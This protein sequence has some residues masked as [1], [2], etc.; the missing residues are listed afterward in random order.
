MQLSKPKNQHSQMFNRTVASKSFLIILVWTIS[1]LLITAHEYFFLSN[2]AGIL[3]T[4]PMV[5][6]NFRNNLIAA[7]FSLGI[8]GLVYCLFEFLYFQKISK[9]FRFWEAIFLRILFYGVFVLCLMAFTSYL[10]NTALSGRSLVD[11]IGL[12]KTKIFITSKSLLH[13]ILPFMVL[14]L[15]SSFFLQL[16]E[17][18]SVQELNRMMSGRYF[19]PKQEEKVILFLDLNHSTMLAEKLG[20]EKFYELINDFFYDI[21]PVI[22]R[23]RGEVVEYVGDQIIVSWNPVQGSLHGNC[24]E[25][26]F[27]FEKVIQLRSSHY[28]KKYGVTPEFK[29]AI[30]SGQVIIGEIGK[31]KK[32]IKFNGDVLNTTSRVEGMCRQ[33]GEKLLLT[34]S[35]VRQFKHITFTTV[36]IA[37]TPLRGKEEMIGIYKVLRE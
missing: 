16:T 29:V 6:Y 28:Q 4:L 17:R 33:L 14:I 35:V 9:R 1:G 27:D 5:D 37:D 2:Y 36:K 3:D 23:H 20:N 31:I 10:Y 25:C 13:P 15:I 19:H 22:E 30:H 12:A 11:P 18:F 8:G 26:I 34:E 7:C 32:S 21:A 24:V